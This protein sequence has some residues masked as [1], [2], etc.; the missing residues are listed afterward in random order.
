[1]L[2]EGILIVEHLT[3]LAALP[4]EGFSSSR[5]ASSELQGR[6]SGGGGRA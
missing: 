3:N 4:D 1:L 2:R 5:A 6:G